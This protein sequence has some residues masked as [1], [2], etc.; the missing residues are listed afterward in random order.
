MSIQHSNNRLTDESFWNNVWSLTGGDAERLSKSGFYFGKNG[1]LVKL[2]RDKVGELRGK[3]VLEFGGGGVNYRLL[4]MAKWMGAETSALDFSDEGLDRVRHLFTAN[5]C[6]GTWIHAD[7]CT[8]TAAQIYDLVVHWG[9]LEH[10]PDPLPILQKSADALKP[11]GKVL[12]SMPNMEAVS[13]AL[14]KKWSPENWSKHVLHP[15]E[16]IE[17]SLRQAGFADIRSFYFGVPFFKTV[18]WEKRSFAQWPI[19]L[20]QKAGSASA[21]VFPVYHRLGHRLISME[22]GFSARKAE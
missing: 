2:I 5:D 6:A 14:W 8:W 1:L 15:S 9:V 16:L 17:S 21:R 11:G 20:L 12:F 3:S 7:I 13:A 18:E 19:D 10:F 4:A 22:R